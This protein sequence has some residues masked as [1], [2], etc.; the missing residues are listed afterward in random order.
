MN[1]LKYIQIAT[2]LTVIFVCLGVVYMRRDTSEN[3]LSITIDP[4]YQ[5]KQ[6]KNDVSTFVAS[7][8]PKETPQDTSQ[9]NTNAVQPITEAN[10]VPV[11]YATIFSNAIAA[12]QKGNSDS[13]STISSDFIAAAC[14][15]SP[16]SVELCEFLEL[17]QTPWNFTNSDWDRIIEIL[18]DTDKTTME[19]F[20]LTILEKIGNGKGATSL[21]NIYQI[22]NV[23]LRLA[24]VV[25]VQADSLTF[26]A[27]AANIVE[28]YD[29]ERAFQMLDETIR[30]MKECENLDPTLYIMTYGKK[31]RYMVSKKRY[32]EAENEYNELFSQKPGG[33]SDE[34]WNNRKYH[35]WYDLMAQYCRVKDNDKIRDKG[36]AALKD[37]MN[38]KKASQG[39]RNAAKYEIERAA[40]LSR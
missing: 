23:L 15:N 21:E 16:D 6:K 18:S 4:I 5:T 7:P 22:E 40:R 2:I 3:N 10:S 32:E 28:L 11:T 12:A 39:L 36:I 37:L 14:S 26:E 35:N 25:P 20:Y 27:C 19:V 38:D 30:K 13:L 24:T 29:K 31:L 33:L 9:L 1:R 8:L 34:T 17:R